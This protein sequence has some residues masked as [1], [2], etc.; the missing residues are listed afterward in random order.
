MTAEN[1]ETGP[2]IV[3][4]RERLW[5]IFEMSLGCLCYGFSC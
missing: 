2:F 4:L 5:D 3:R 1:K